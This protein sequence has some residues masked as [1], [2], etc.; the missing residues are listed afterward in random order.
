M[1]RSF[2]PSEEPRTGI[3]VSILTKRYV[4]PLLFLLAWAFPA[5]AQAPGK[6]EGGW[7]DSLCLKCH[8][9][10]KI[11]TMP[12]SYRLAMVR[13][14]GGTGRSRPPGFVKRLYLG[15]GSGLEG[16]HKGV[17]CVSCHQNISSIPH[18]RFLPPPAGCSKCHPKE[19]RSYEGGIHGMRK[20]MGDPLAPSCGDC[21]GRA[22]RVLPAGD[23][24]SPVHPLNI[25]RTC[26]NCHA[27]P[28]IVERNKAKLEGRVKNY[29]E[30]VHGKGL[31]KAGLVVSATCADCHG[32][33]GILPSANPRSP[34]NPANL[35]DLCE[36]CHL[37]LKAKLEKSVHGRARRE[38]NTKAPTCQSCHESHKIL[39]TQRRSGFPMKTPGKCGHCHPKEYKSYLMSF[40]GKAT[41]FGMA[42]AALCIDCHDHHDILPPNDPASSVNPENLL[43]TCRR[44]HPKAEKR[45]T[46]YHP[47]ADFRNKDKYPIE[48]W[49]WFLM[50]TLLVCTIAFFGL[51]TVL[52]FIREAVHILRHGRH[53]A[54]PNP[55]FI[56]RY[57]LYHRLT[58]VVIIVSFLGLVATGMPL[59]FADSP[60]A[61]SVMN[62]FGG[63]SVARVIHRFCAFLTLV[64]VV[65]HLG[66]LAKIF[67]KAGIR[68][69]GR[70]FFGPDSMV[71]S[72]KDLKDMIGHFK[73]FLF[74]G[75]R[76]KF[77]R[78]TYWDKFD[79]WGEFW[80]VT[81]IG[82][83]GL[84]LW[85]P[86]F[87]SRF[88][89]GWIFNVALVVHSIEA[90]LAASI[91]FLVHFFNVH[92]RPSKFPI[93]PVIFT[94]CMTEEEFKEEHPLE[95]ERLL[96]SG[97]L[98]KRIV[99]FRRGK[100][101]LLVRVL[102]ICA[103]MVGLL[104][105]VLIF[106]GEMQSIL[107]NGSL[108]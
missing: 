18:D 58:H 70:F 86:E 45:F 77:D 78:W 17:S 2:R 84:L 57:P 15:P 3:P 73:W 100:R 91:I 61:S 59:K 1:T 87:F 37:G 54:G 25:S 72:P 94:G 8:G 64:Y 4:F 9:D 93:D 107:G 38:G 11:S 44:C 30:S 56:Q 10:K 23:P 67:S 108:K 6:A 65:M 24:A 52:W 76:P 103:F 104:F 20:K 71:F 105:L 92:L 96:A 98:E 34:T 82:L 62:F 69:I 47:H 21:H 101:F 42:S 22:H 74:M 16:P 43:R 106:V 85:F 46:L 40:H 102:G 88:L 12:D 79:Y 99:S 48:Y 41:R 81:V 97:E 27:K 63:P 89:P 60:W 35:E 29:W 50:T 31:K 51:H 66:F 90:L 55:R 68:R 14:G 75:P 39:S 28:E 33:H 26:G 32:S 7:K 83:S 95:Y 49:A 36:K 53:H 5:A 19:T 80:G 13:S